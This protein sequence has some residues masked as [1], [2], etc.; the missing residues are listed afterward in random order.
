MKNISDIIKKFFGGWQSYSE[1]E[2]P[3]TFLKYFVYYPLNWSW[4]FGSLLFIWIFI[5]GYIKYESQLCLTA[6]LFPL[7]MLVY[8]FVDE[9]YA[10]Q[11]YVT[12]ARKISAQTL[13]RI[14]K[15]SCSMIMLYLIIRTFVTG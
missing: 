1:H 14:V 15:Y 12:G 2:R 3:K 10:F 6:T 7:I 9:Y 5:N 11:W 13:Q 4:T 8:N